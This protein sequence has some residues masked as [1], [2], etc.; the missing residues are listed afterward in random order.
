MNRS[1]RRLSPFQSLQLLLSGHILWWESVILIRKAGVVL[2][3]VLV[4]NAYLQNA[5][6]ALWFAMAL[7]LQLSISPYENPTFN[8]MEALGL[9][10]SFST[11]VVASTLLQYDVKDPTFSTEAASSMTSMQ[12][13]ITGL[14]AFINIGTLIIMGGVWIWLL[15]SETIQR[16]I[17][18]LP[19]SERILGCCISKKKALSGKQDAV[20]VAQP[21]TPR[22]T[23][24]LRNGDHA[25][26]SHQ[27]DAQQTENPLNSTPFSAASSSGEALSGGNT[28]AIRSQ[29]PPQR[30]QH[31]DD[32]S[33]TPALTSSAGS[34]RNIGGGAPA[35]LR[36]LSMLRLPPSSIVSSTN[37]SPSESNSSEKR[38]QFLNALRAQSRAAGNDAASENAS[39]V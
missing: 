35:L 15:F 11:A 38:Q 1:H 14:L 10:S 7:F 13:A 25:T 26:S 16:I 32:L 5:G 22:F 27:E 17:R 31:D 9:A 21:S 37:S 6:A 34:T 8:K 29:F 36:R 2:L 4:T 30:Q 33:P 18:L 20:V 28:M 24:L 3:A 39:S 19:C 12:W 23:P